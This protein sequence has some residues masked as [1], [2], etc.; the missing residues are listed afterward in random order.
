MKEID[1][2]GKACPMPVVLT[3]RALKESPDE[4]L[5]IKVDNE[6]ATQ[7]LNKMAEQLGLTCT[8]EQQDAQHYDVYLF[9][10]DKEETASKKKIPQTMDSSKKEFME[11]DSYIVVLHSDTLG[12]GAKELGHTLMKSF[13]FALSEQDHLPHTL[14]FYNGGA[15]LT[16]QGSPVLEDLKAMEEAGTEILTCGI[17][18]EY[19]NFTEKLA[20]GSATNMYRIVELQ[21]SFKTVS[22]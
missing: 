4:T 13:L 1:A 15:K 21:R 7:N 18:L 2:L 10:G 12:E 20:V 6:I 8:I 22:P 9:G 5:K 11:E 14:I 17:C 16:T 3:K 19:F